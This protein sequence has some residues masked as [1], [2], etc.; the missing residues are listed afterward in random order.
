MPL[1]F[2]KSSAPVS[3]ETKLQV[4]FD[5]A[6]EDYEQGKYDDALYCL[7]K[8]LALQPTHA[9]ALENQGAITS[10]ILFTEKA[11]E[12]YSNA[13]T[14]NEPAI[15]E[16]LFRSALLYCE[17]ALKIDPLNYTALRRKYATLYQLAQHSDALLTIEAA[18]NDTKLAQNDPIIY[19]D[20]ASILN[21]LNRHQDAYESAMQ[22]F[23]LADKHEEDRSLV[24]Y[25][26]IIRALKKVN[27]LEHALV[28]S[29]EALMHYPEDRKLTDQRAELLSLL[30]RSAET[31]QRVRT[32]GSELQGSA[33]ALS[34]VGITARAEA[35]GGAG[36]SADAGVGATLRL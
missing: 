23:A 22:S 26:A 11:A 33:A 7:T 21:L 36:V 1:I 17:Q 8:V 20:Q 3:A 35:G 15:W 34:S 9:E 6:A 10:I 30:H 2:T 12:L 18:L 5:Q 27:D 24:A 13:C 16:E 4:F 25:K 29:R 14:E 28:W 31:N 19:A 32:A